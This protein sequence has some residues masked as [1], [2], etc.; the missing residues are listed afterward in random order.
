MPVCGQEMRYMCVTRGRVEWSLQGV[1]CVAIL[2]CA[3]F[4]GEGRTSRVTSRRI[5]DD[6][7]SHPCIVSLTLVGSN[8]F[9]IAIPIRFYYTTTVTK[10]V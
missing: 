6:Y 9:D 1:I 4:P 10:I 8:T 7:G 2:Q 3:G 5:N